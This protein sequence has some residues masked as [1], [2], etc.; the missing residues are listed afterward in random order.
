MASVNLAAGTVGLTS[1]SSFQ[2][3]GVI[4]T[5]QT[6]TSNTTVQA[7]TFTN[8]G[9]ISLQNNRVGDA[10]TINGN[11]VGVPGS[12]IALDFATLSG[13][14]D[15]VTI[16]GN[17]SGTTGLLLNNVTPLAPFTTTTPLVQVNGTT[18]PGVFSL[19]ALQNVNPLISFLLVPEI[20]GS[21]QRFSLGAAPTAAG[22]SGAVASLAAFNIGFLTQDAVFDHLQDTRNDIRRQLLA[23]QTPGS[24]VMSYQPV[25]MKSAAV[26]ESLHPLSDRRSVPPRGREDMATSSVETR[27]RPSPSGA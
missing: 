3:N 9:G 22:L 8:A 1:L 16:N 19:V 7:T 23:A 18:T 12:L 17:A 15:Q 24:Q 6:G 11:Y 21:G 20:A 4:L 2:N 13:S 10:F 25:A 14:A 26:A 5:S 27:R